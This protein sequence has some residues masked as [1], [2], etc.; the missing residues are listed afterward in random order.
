MGA[1][2]LRVVIFL[3]FGVD[4]SIQICLLAKSETCA[5]GGNE[6]EDQYRTSLQLSAAC[7]RVGRSSP[8][9]VDLVSNTPGQNYVSYELVAELSSIQFYYGR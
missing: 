5:W 9:T 1:E 6:R 4:S 7:D 2:V 8:C 3:R